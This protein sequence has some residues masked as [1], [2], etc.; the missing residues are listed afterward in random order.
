MTVYSYAYVLNECLAES[1]FK[2]TDSDNEFKH[3]NQAL[4][5]LLA[6]RK[7]LASGKKEPLSHEDLSTAIDLMASI[8]TYANRVAVNKKE[9]AKLQRKQEKMSAKFELLAD[10]FLGVSF[11]HQTET[12]YSSLYI[13]IIGQKGTMQTC[14]QESN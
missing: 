6:K 14:A 2:S 9:V 8:Q 7:I 3:A 1:S 12:S 5:D 13:M 11:V 4:T 10:A